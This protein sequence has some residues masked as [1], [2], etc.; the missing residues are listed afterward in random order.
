[1]S[2]NASEDTYYIQH[3]TG[4]LP[5]KIGSVELSS[6]SI[7]WHYRNGISN[8][9]LTM[10]TDDC[11]IFLYLYQSRGNC[12][13]S[14]SISVPNGAVV[15]DIYAQHYNQ[16]GDV[17][18]TLAYVFR[19]KSGQNKELPFLLSCRTSDPGATTQ[20]IFVVGL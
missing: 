2:Y 20:S 18:S 19:I 16:V 9:S 10:P 4:A 11:L 17:Y 5:V 6:Q 8:V 15:E 1:M 14:A 13:L 12:N 3:E 7:M